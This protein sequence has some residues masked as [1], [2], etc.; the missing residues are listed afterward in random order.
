MRYR[1]DI[2]S[3]KHSRARGPLVLGH[4]FSGYVE[5]LDRKSTFSIGDRVVIEPTLNCGCCEDC[6]SW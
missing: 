1:Y 5:E 3:G 4:E 6:T 2:Y